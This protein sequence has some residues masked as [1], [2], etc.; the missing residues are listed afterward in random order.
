MVRIDAK[1]EVCPMPVIMAKKALK[2]LPENG[3]I[4]ISVDNKTATENLEKLANSSGYVIKTNMVSDEHYDVTITK[5]E[6]VVID[7]TASQR[8]GAVVVITSDK[9]GEGDDVLG[10]TLMK[11][12]IYTLTEL[13]TLPEKIIFYNGGAKITGGASQYAD[14]CIT[15]LKKLVDMGVEILTC[16]ACLNYY[17]LTDSLAVGTVTNMY[18]IAECLLASDK[19]IKP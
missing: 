16:G 3:F 19:I 17:N 1:G 12:F 13:D 4:V 6:V 2:D 11:G 18:S 5:G 14:D 8:N 10:A 7:E 9:M 15:D